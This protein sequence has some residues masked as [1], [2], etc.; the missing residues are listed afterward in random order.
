MKKLLFLTLLIASFSGI[1]AQSGFDWAL[2][3][4]HPYYGE[5]KSMLAPAEDGTFLMAGNF[6]DTAAF[7]D[8]SVIS[9]G[10]TDIFIASHNSEGDCQWTI[11]DGGSNYD[12]LHGIASTNNSIYAGGSFYGTTQ[13]GGE[14]FTSLGSQDIFIARYDTEGSFLWAKHIGSPKT[15]YLNAIASDPEGNIILTGHFYDSVAFGDTSIYALA[16]SD[17]FLAKYNPMGELLW[18]R[19]AGGSSADQSYTLDCDADGNILFTG[20]YFLDIQIGDTLLSTLDPTGVFYAQY[21]PDGDFLSAMQADGNGLT[22]QSFATYDQDG[23]IFFTGN[24]T[25]EVKFGPYIFNA[26]AFNIDIFISSFSTEGELLWADHGHGAG[27]DQLMSVSKGP[28]NDFYIAG[29]YLD[30]LHFGDLTLD[31]TLCCGSAEIFLVRYTA[32]G[33]P[34]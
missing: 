29:H 16:G 27:S 10:E 34:S 28:F 22:A 26:G 8:I 3:C 2:V 32:D 23:N 20:S 11:S 12:Y 15:D 25:D 5:T 6:I 4:G 13:L 31:Y 1:H 21:G 18:I 24:F 14:E 9:S 33:M 19:R 7:G 17:I 30:T